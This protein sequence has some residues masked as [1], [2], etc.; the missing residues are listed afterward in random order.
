MRSGR[1]EY[2]G[3]AVKEIEMRRGT[4]V[5]IVATLLAVGAIAT[6]MAI[7]YGAGFSDGSATDT[8]NVAPWVFGG[9]FV[10]WHI[11]GLIVSLF[12]LLLVFRLM[13]LI[14]FGHR[15]SHW[16]RAADEYGPA[17]QPGPGPWH[18]GWHHGDWRSRGD[19]RSPG[20]A[21][22]EWHRQAHGTAGPGQPGAGG[23]GPTGPNGPAAG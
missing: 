6:L 1:P 16:H 14:V 9:A 5:R 11:V 13:A 3:S 2:S 10:G 23:A 15:Y 19:W 17:G 22:E 8:R 20:Q 7:A 4:W 21:F 12:V 18:R